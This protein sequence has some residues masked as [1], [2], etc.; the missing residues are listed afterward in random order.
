[1]DEKRYFILENSEQGEYK[2]IK[3]IAISLNEASISAFVLHYRFNPYEYPIPQLNFQRAVRYLR[4]HASEF[5]FDSKNIS[6]RFSAGGNQIG[7]YLN[8]IMGNAY[9]PEDYTPDE[10]DSVEDSV[11]A[12]G[13]I[14][15]A[16]TYKYNVPM[17]SSFDANAVRDEVT[18]KKLL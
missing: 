13:M 8:L 18:R 4:Y 11:L 14:Y 2:K 10:I 12:M 16:L 7:A 6:L 17:L 1:M 5:G 9:F 15:P 3:D